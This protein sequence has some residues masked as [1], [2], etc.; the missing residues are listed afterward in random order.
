MPAL[1]AAAIVLLPFDQLPYFY[2]ELKAF[3]LPAAN[4]PL[5]ALVAAWLFLAV[6]GKARL[7]R[8]KSVRFF[9]AFIAWAAL[10]S[11]V[12][13]RAILHSFPINQGSGPHRMLTQSAA[14]AFSFLAAL[15]IAHM[16]LSGKVSLRNVSRWALWSFV[17]VALYCIPELAYLR[18]RPHWA[19]AI[20]STVAP[21]VRCTPGRCDSFGL[22]RLPAF[23][24]PRLHGLSSEPA[25]FGIYLAFVLPWIASRAIKLERRRWFWALALAYAC[26]LAFCTASQTA[27]AIAAAEIGAVILIGASESPQARKPLLRLSAFLAAVLAASFAVYWGH[28]YDDSGISADFLR[29]LVSPHNDGLRLAGLK[30]ALFIAARHP[31]L[32]TGIGQIGPYLTPYLLHHGVPINA[33]MLTTTALHADIL[34]QTGTVGLGLWL[35]AWLYAFLA[36]WRAFRKSRD[37]V[38]SLMPALFAVGIGEFLSLLAAFN[39]WIPGAWIWLGLVWGCASAGQKSGV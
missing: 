7:P 24:F 11:L 19:A 10:S 25:Y 1:L 4:F 20:L 32:G 36:A 14:L 31:L 16:V 38:A 15:S 21:K 8:E 3:G 13:L 37:S 26:L 30:G 17:P 5:A 18:S 33:P 27:Y 23:G 39:F 35:L 28:V 29:W 9:L 12:N 34:V 22:L 6:R 2:R